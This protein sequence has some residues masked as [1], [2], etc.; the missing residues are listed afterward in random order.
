MVVFKRLAEIIVKG[1][2][3]AVLLLDLVKEAQ[4][5][6][7]FCLL[8]V[9]VREDR[10]E[11]AGGE[12]KRNDTNEHH[13][14]AHDLLLLGASRNVPET[15]RCDGCEGEIKRCD[16]KANVGSILVTVA[17]YPSLRA[18]IIDSCHENPSM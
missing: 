17:N 10:T 1:I 6:L 7:E 12:S 14:D 13:D 4:L 9:Y 18:K 8:A 2:S 15:D 11:R 5:L 3:D 16:V